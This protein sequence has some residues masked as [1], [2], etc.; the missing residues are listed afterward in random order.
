MINVT[1][2]VLSMSSYLIKCVSNR[3]FFNGMVILLSES[4]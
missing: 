2:C 1:D 4:T 3:S